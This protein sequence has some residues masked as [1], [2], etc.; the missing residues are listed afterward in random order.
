MKKI[1]TI[2]F[3]SLFAVKVLAQHGLAFHH[4]GNATFQNTQFNAANFP[5]GRL[6]VGVPLLSGI[7]V[8]YNNALSYNDL[9]TKTESGNNLI[10]VEKALGELDAQN[11]ISVSSMISL[12]HVGFRTPH[13]AA[14]SFFANERIEVD[15]LFPR[16]LIEFGWEG[17]GTLIGEKTKLGQMAVNASHFREFGV[18]YA[19][20]I[21]E[22][23][24]AIG[25]RAKYYV[26]FVNVSSP[27]G[28][29][30]DVTTEVENNQLNV[31]LK[32]AVL[33]TSGLDIIQGNEGSLGSH[34][35]FNGNRGFG[36]DLGF[37]YQVTPR[38]SVSLGL[39]DIGFMSW[40][41][42]ITNHV[43]NDTSF[44]Y[45]GVPDLK[46]GRNI[47]DY[48]QDSLIDQFSRRKNA[49]AYSAPMVATAFG[50]V[51]Y[52]FAPTT[53]IIG[54]IAGRLVQGLPRASLAVGVRQSFG[55]AITVSGTVTKLPQRFINL[56]VAFA[57]QAGPVQFYMASDKVVGY[58]V[59]DTRAAEFRFGINLIFGE[60]KEKV[61]KYKGLQTKG[62]NSSRFMGKKVNVKGQD[63][64][65]TIINKQKRRKIKN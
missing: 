49:D 42:D 5:E 15:F 47:L 14:L 21:P 30:A 17:N 38:Y 8:F 11:T 6:F 54:T 29:T 1:L 22:Y 62:F 39:N 64:I 45:L 32:E 9:F 65:Y 23:R 46:E 25:I 40:K 13:G 31:D 20:R 44:V 61:E 35:I 16:R 50:S 57:A 24:I 7:N 4:L 56:G 51:T 18:G 63:G 52:R 59:P 55:S 10:D 27:I 37:D 2:S 34:L 48:I 19:Y 60:R 28:L 33:R 3:I 43:I 53:D 26:G 41:E 12:F 58:S 36:V